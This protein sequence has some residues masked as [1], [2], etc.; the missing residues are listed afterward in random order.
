MNVK[1][2]TLNLNS[3]GLTLRNEGSIPAYKTRLI[4]NLALGSTRFLPDKHI[5]GKNG[6]IYQNNCYFGDNC[7]DKLGVIDAANNDNIYYDRVNDGLEWIRD[8]R[9]NGHSKIITVS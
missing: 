4:Y 5:L 9:K 7:Y 2:S 6:N 8:V 1:T 3:N